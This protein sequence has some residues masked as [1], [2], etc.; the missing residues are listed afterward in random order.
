MLR[1][2][3][4]MR[5]GSLGAI[6]KPSNKHYKEYDSATTNSSSRSSI[7]YQECANQLWKDMNATIHM[8][9]STEHDCL[10]WDF[11]VLFDVWGCH[12]Y[13]IDIDRC[14]QRDNRPPDQEIS[15]ESIIEDLRLRYQLLVRWKQKHEQEEVVEKRNLKWKE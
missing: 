3:L 5:N 10:L 9:N 14:A 1:N 2:P 11:Q 4:A 15:T 6:P 13:H 7:S 12:L 8:V